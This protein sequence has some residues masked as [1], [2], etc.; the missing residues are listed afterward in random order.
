[1][2]H[3]Q[4]HKHLQYVLI[5]VYIQIYPDP[6]CIYANVCKVAQLKSCN[7]MQWHDAVLYQIIR[8][9]LIPHFSDQ[10]L[11]GSRMKLRI[12]EQH[13]TIV[14]D[15]LKVNEQNATLASKVAVM[16]QGL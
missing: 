8:Q 2:K 12:C 10:I 6:I 16:T 14:N 5:Q 4:H 7:G 15:A 9:I 1:M 11:L 3:I 13:P